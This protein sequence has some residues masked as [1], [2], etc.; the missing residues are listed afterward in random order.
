MMTMTNIQWK[1]A[2]LLM[3]HQDLKKHAGIA[4]QSKRNEKKA[5]E[6]LLEIKEI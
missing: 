4:L 1:V 5:N 3:I 2:V 6:L